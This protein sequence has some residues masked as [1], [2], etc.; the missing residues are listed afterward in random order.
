MEGASPDPS[1]CI[2]KPSPAQG[3]HQHRS[4]N[5]KYGL[6]LEHGCQFTPLFLQTN[7]LVS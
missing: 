1:V 7:L 6:E 2:P 4:R 3:P 5:W